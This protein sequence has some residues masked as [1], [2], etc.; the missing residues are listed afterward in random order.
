MSTQ[1][2][3]TIGIVMTGLVL[4]AALA[5]LV[6]AIQN[7]RP[8]VTDCTIRSF[9]IAYIVFF[10]IAVLSM[11]GVGTAVFRATE[12]GAT[13]GGTILAFS[14]VALFVIAIALAFNA[15]K[16]SDEG[17]RNANYWVFGLFAGLSLINTLYIFSQR[18]DIVASQPGAQVLDY[19]QNRLGRSPLTTGAGSFGETY[20]ANRGVRT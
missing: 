9:S 6:V 7:L 18:S 14:S 11:L 10:V 17:S 12:L 5:G 3:Q 19:V 1:T 13:A 20:R 2:R 4:V 15:G 8:Q 16:I